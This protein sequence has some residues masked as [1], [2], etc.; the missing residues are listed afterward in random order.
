M[1]RGLLWMARHSF[2]LYD[3][4]FRKWGPE[5]KYFK[6]APVALIIQKVPRVWGSV[7]QE[8][9]YIL[10]IWMT[11]Y[12]YFLWI[13]IPHL[14]SQLDSFP[15]IESTQSTNTNI[16]HAVHTPSILY[17]LVCFSCKIDYAKAS[18]S[19]D[20]NK[21]WEILKEMGI[22]GYLTCFLRN[23]YAY[24]EETEPDLK[25]QAGSKLGK[26]YIKA[27]YYHPA[28]L[29]YAQSTSCEM[30]GWMMCKLI[31]NTGENINNLRYADDT[32]LM[33]EREEELKSLLMK[34]KEES[35][36]VGLNLNIQKN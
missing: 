32:I 1:E 21:L 33:A 8:P 36:K 24:Q 2:H 5:V 17:Q 31:K 16:W 35:A 4:V 9:W 3:S 19:V 27:V 22:P 18:D 15:V 7:I 10:F 30:P 20:S 14:C 12:I 23:L 11:K 13:T 25:Q 26:E 29:T 34:V 28:Y 6:N